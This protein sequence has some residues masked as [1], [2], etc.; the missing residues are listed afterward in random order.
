[1]PRKVLGNRSRDLL[2]ELASLLLEIAGL[3]AGTERIN[4]GS[5]TIIAHL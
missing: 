1:M 4:A 2:C 5:A 3:L